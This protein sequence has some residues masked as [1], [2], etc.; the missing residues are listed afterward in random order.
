[1]TLHQHRSRAVSLL[2]TGH[3]LPS[4]VMTSTDLDRTLN[5]APGTI[6]RL[7]GVRVRHFA[8][9]D[10]TAAMLAAAAASL[11]LADIDCLVAASGTQD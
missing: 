5:H 1:M 8:R 11:A 10:E 7:S 2:G 3:A 4:V 9:R 6:E